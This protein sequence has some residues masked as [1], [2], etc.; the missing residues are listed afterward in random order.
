MVK[1]GLSGRTLEEAGDG[2]LGRQAIGGE[3]G[4]RGCRA[5]PSAWI[6]AGPGSR[7]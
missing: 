3:A 2:R 5:M 1:E 6:A 4:S 7:G